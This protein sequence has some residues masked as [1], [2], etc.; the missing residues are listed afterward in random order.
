[1]L[2]V[3]FESVPL[4][5]ETGLNELVPEDRVG[6]GKQM[7]IGAARDQAGSQRERRR[8]GPPYNAI[9][10]AFSFSLR[11]Q[12]ELEGSLMRV[13]VSFVLP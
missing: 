6:T 12:N 4:G 9:L 1:M 2:G 11:L 10:L 7:P 13:G 8:C 3:Q 5:Y